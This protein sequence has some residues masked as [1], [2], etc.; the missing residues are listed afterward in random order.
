MNILL[1]GAGAVGQVYGRHLQLGGA[2]VS[3][4][5]KPKYADDVKKG[6]TLY[7]LNSDR[8]REKPMRFEGF[9][10]L[11][12]I[13]EVAAKSWDAVML[14]VSST[15]LRAMNL[16]ELAKAAGN[17]SI[18]MLQPG[19]E[20]H[21]YVTSLSSPE[22]VVAGMIS[23]VSYHTPLPGETVKEPGTAYWFPPL[24]P[25][26]FSGPDASRVR[27][28]VDTL[29]RGGQPAAVQKDVPSSVV[30]PSAIL[31][32]FIAGLEEAGWS[33]N[34]LA[35]GKRLSVVMQAAKES[36]SVANASI[37]KRAPPIGPLLQP[38]LAKIALKIA[39]GVVPFDLETYLRVHFTKVGDQTRFMLAQYA[40]HG[41][42]KGLPV[43]SLESLLKQ[44]PPAA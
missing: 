4:L 18:V 14:C 26:P 16:G 32:C 5:V 28:I 36:L 37:G 33:L 30:A 41:K 31:M 34:T 2:N 22:R 21:A 35:D 23:L 39:P 29:K 15:A 43:S 24:A 13:A 9:G 3:F 38:G 42:Q 20:D 27:A 12:D 10:V 11:T 6:F 17:A 1:V 44:L 7:Q 8:R 19:M 40:E 25:S